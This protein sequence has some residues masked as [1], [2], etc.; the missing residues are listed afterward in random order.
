MIITFENRQQEILYLKTSCTKTKR[1]S[2]NKA[3]IILTIN[4]MDQD[5]KII[6]NFTGLA[7]HTH[8]FGIHDK[9]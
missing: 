4:F 3:G 6:K 1:G 8:C 2:K 5:Y 9:V 7:I